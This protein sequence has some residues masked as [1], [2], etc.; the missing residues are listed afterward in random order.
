MVL[1][2]G[3]LPAMLA[4]EAVSRFV[5]GVLGR[6]G[7]AEADSFADGLIVWPLGKEVAGFEDAGMREID[8]ES[9]PV[10]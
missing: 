7:A 6:S 3:E 9:D 2:G 4:I 10:F 5:P 1:S 8:L